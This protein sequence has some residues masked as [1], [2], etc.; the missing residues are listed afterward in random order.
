MGRSL[1]GVRRIFSIL[2]GLVGL[3]GLSVA[4]QK[5]AQAARTLHPHPRFIWWGPRPRAKR[6]CFDTYATFHGRRSLPA[7]S[8][9]AG[10]ADSPLTFRK[11]P[12]LV[13]LENHR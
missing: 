9:G 12:L 13:S 8:C 10:P 11:P 7:Q 3:L 6:R 5:I 2:S 4:S 1:V